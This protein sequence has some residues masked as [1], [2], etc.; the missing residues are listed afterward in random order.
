M[1]NLENLDDDILRRIT[2]FV[3]DKLREEEG[4][5]AEE[6]RERMRA[7]TRLVLKYYR[8]LV[9]HAEQAISRASQAE[10]DITLRDLLDMMRR[11]GREDFRVEA[12]RCS[13][14]MSRIMV[15][16]IDAMFEIYRASAE[17]SGKADAIRRSKLIYELYLAPMRMTVDEIVARDFCDRSTV[18]RDIRRACES[19]AILL[20]G[21]YGYE[22]L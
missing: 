14:A 20:F 21:A 15:D 2:R 4:K 22:F 9:E 18:Y 11:T 3:V 1:G 16:H 10:Y 12:I 19:L 7:N 6:Q 8:E 5:Q 13:A 17:K